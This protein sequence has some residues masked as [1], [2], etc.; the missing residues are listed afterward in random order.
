[1]GVKKIR[2]RLQEL[3]DEE[4]EQLRRYETANKK[5]STLLARFDQRLGAS[6]T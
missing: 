6:S 4:V 3:T 1:L 5:R 2:E